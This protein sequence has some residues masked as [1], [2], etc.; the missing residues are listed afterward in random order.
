M[1]VRRM[2]RALTAWDE[3]LSR[4]SC[5]KAVLR[6]TFRRSLEAGESLRSGLL[7]QTICEDGKGLGK[8]LRLEVFETLELFVIDGGLLIKESQLPSSIKS[9]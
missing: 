2:T 5:L 1:T 9:V 3:S 4:D 7:N 6:D 8:D